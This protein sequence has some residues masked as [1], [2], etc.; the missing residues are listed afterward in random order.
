MFLPSCF[1]IKAPITEQEKE[2]RG[3]LISCFVTPGYNCTLLSH[4]PCIGRPSCERM[5]IQ[6]SDMLRITRGCK[7]TETLPVTPAAITLGLA[8]VAQTQKQERI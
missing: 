8:T 4:I 5:R 2:K 6:W 3:T 1:P 7:A